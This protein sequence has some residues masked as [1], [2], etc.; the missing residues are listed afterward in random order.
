MVHILFQ[1][2]LVFFLSILQKIKTP[3]K[4]SNLIK[5]QFVGRHFKM[6][7]PK[8]NIHSKKSFSS[9][10]FNSMLLEID[11][12]LGWIDVDARPT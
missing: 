6:L 8:R 10:S 4:H 2:S 7:A 5:K 1:K 12:N 11:K 9:K 3:F